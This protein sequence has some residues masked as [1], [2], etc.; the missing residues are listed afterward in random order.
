VTRSKTPSANTQDRRAFL[1]PPCY[2]NLQTLPGPKF[3]YVCASSQAV[4]P[5]RDTPQ[6]KAAGINIGA[7]RLP[8]MSTNK[9][10]RRCGKWKGIV[11]SLR[12]S[13]RKSEATLTMNGLAPVCINH[14]VCIGIPAGQRCSMKLLHITAKCHHNK[15]CYPQQIANYNIIDS[16]LSMTWNFP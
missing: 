1:R 8:D 12:V 4:C 7:V 3:H 16:L 10:T 5:S 9:H 6:G 13:S 2:T 14:C 15:Q 11:L